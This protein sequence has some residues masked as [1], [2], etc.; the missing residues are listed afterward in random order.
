MNVL[1]KQNDGYLCKMCMEHAKLQHEVGINL[2]ECACYN[3]N[4]FIEGKKI[5]WHKL[6][7]FPQFPTLFPLNLH[8]YD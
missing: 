3:E 5:C 6:A 1:G 7:I 4:V 8:E 2:V